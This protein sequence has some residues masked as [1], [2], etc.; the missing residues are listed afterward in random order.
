MTIDCAPGGPGYEPLCVIRSSI[1]NLL[2]DVGSVIALGIHAPAAIGDRLDRV[3]ANADSIAA[4]AAEL[5]GA[6]ALA[7]AGGPVEGAW[8]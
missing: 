8:P 5:R 4:A 3:L 2:Q 6:I 1:Y 7:E